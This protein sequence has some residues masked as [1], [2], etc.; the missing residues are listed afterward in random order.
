M[1]H[2]I[3][4]E[5]NL[6]FSTVVAVET[7]MTKLQKKFEEGEISAEAYV[8]MRTSILA[9]IQEYSQNIETKCK[10]LLVKRPHSEQRSDNE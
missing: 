5:S 8:T 6:L 10:G 4:P 3:N 2:F 1:K 7:A 9:S